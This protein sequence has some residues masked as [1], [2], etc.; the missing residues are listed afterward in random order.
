MKEDSEARA[1]VP[2]DIVGLDF[3]PLLNTQD[4]D[5]G[6]AIGKITHKED[7]CLVEVY[8]TR[9]G[10]R[11]GQYVVPELTVKSGQWTF[12]NFHYGKP[13]QTEDA[14]LLGI[15]KALRE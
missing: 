1:K 4:P 2:G 8:G 9:S 10:T 13:N 15:L 12:M 14:N 5:E 11:S 7:S 3:D 6:Y